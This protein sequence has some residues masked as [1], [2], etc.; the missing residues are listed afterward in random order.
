VLEI[1][2]LKGKGIES[3]NKLTMIVEWGG[4]ILLEDVLKKWLI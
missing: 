3:H 2:P 1:A 4:N